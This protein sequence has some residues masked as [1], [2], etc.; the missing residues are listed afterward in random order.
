[1]SKVNTGDT[2]TR[3]WVLRPGDFRVEEVTDDIIKATCGKYADRRFGL[4]MLESFNN[5]FRS[6]EEAEEASLAIRTYL[7]SF[8]V[9]LEARQRSALRTRTQ[10]GNIELPDSQDEK[11]IR[12][13][14]IMAFKGDVVNAN[15]ALQFVNGNPEASE[16][17]RRFME[18]QQEKFRQYCERTGVRLGGPPTSSKEQ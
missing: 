14:L 7:A 15:T 2:P 9:I 13:K 18:W 8:K 16:D 3:Y 17:Y 11:M 4:E 5:L 10:S 6:E 1:M 12:L